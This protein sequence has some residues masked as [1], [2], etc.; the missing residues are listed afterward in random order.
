MAIKTKI[1]K[2]FLLLVIAIVYF[3]ATTLFVVKSFAYPSDYK[4]AKGTQVIPSNQIS[5][6]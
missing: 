5:K 2:I 6:H 4:G 3:K 1:L